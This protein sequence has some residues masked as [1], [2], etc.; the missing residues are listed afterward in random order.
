MLKKL[1]KRLVI[2]YLALLIISQLFSSCMSFKMTTQE[3]NTKFKGFGRKPTEHK[4]KV[5]VSGK[6]REINYAEIGDDSKPVVI[7]IHGSPGSWNAFIDF[8]HDSTLLEKVKIVSIDRPG[9]G[10]S[11][12]GDAESS[13]EKQAMFI[14]PILEK[15]KIN[16]NKIILIGH[17][18]GGPMIARMAMDYPQLIDKLIFVAAS[19]DPKLEP[20]TWYRII[21]DSFLVRYIL[22]KSL[23]ASNREILYLKPELEGMLP[24]WAT[25]KHPCIVIQGEDDVLVHPKNAEFA[26]KQLQNAESVQVW[27]ISGMN[28]FV[29]WS[30]PQLIREAILKSL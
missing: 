22:P 6:E 28:H 24:F 5:V 30:H 4:I 10:D 20:S 27:L 14:K 15:Y 29:P 9:F 23:R 8:M 12:L 1:T 18:L 21:G 16:G 13:L 17:S 3:I 7:F 26:Q 19:I 11:G 2:S 25:I